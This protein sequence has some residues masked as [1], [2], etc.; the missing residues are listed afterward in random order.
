MYA[1]A[2]KIQVIE[3][4]LKINNAAPLQ[5]LEK[6]LQKWKKSKAKKSSIYDFVGVLSATEARQMKKAIEETSETI[7]ADE[8]K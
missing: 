3:E 4:V 1:E 6:V 2:K 7:N 5:E 8:W